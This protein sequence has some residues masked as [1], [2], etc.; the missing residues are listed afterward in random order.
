MQRPA[1]NGVPAWLGITFNYT[2][3]SDLDAADAIAITSLEP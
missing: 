3:V 1:H 2:T